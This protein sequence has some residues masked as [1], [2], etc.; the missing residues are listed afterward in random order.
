MSC[1]IQ[2]LR[3]L[4]WTQPVELYDQTKITNRTGQQIDLIVAIYSCD[5]REFA[6]SHFHPDREGNFTITQAYCYIPE[7]AHISLFGY[8]KGCPPLLLGEKH[9]SFTKFFSL[10]NHDF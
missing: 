9:L 1:S 6:N 4:E 2:A 5:Q 8:Q 3:R 10:Q 7:E